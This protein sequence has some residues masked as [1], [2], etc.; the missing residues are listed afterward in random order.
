MLIECH[1]CVCPFLVLQSQGAAEPPRLDREFS[2]NKL[3][4]TAPASD[5]EKPTLDL[6][7]KQ[8]IHTSSKKSR[9]GSAP[10]RSGNQEYENTRIREFKNGAADRDLRSRAQPGASAFLYSPPGDIVVR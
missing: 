10:L 7:L 1:I 5:P 4:R 2:D 8:Y 6:S 9:G 3:S